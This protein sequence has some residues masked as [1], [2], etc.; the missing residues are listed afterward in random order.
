MTVSVW[1]PADRRGWDPRQWADALRWSFIVIETA[2]A[3]AGPGRSTALRHQGRIAEV[4]RALC[5]EQPIVLDAVCGTTLTVHPDSVVAVCDADA[6]EDHHVFAG[7]L[8]TDDSDQGCLERLH[9]A[10]DEADGLPAFGGQQHMTPCASRAGD[11]TRAGAS[12]ASESDQRRLTPGSRRE[13][14]V[15]DEAVRHPRFWTIRTPPGEPPGRMESRPES[16]PGP[17]HNPVTLRW[18]GHDVAISLAGSARS[19]LV[20]LT[21][22]DAV[23]GGWCG[24]RVLSPHELE[25]LVA[26]LDTRFSGNPPAA[27]DDG[28]TDL[29]TLLAQLLDH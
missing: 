7:C 12:G 8:G 15:S 28:D 18:L 29:T 14:N 5:A 22:W 13:A 21:W 17:H 25:R 10:L 27:T 20:G 2:P 11:K 4:G 24:S 19:P 16:S 23:T 9:A 26:A 6:H 1:H 3:S